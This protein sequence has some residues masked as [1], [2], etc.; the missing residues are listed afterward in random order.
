MRITPSLNNTWTCND[1]DPCMDLRVHL[2]LDLCVLH[3]LARVTEWWH[4]Q[5]DMIW[6]EHN[7]LHCTVIYFSC[8]K[9][10]ESH[11]S[12][13]I[14]GFNLVYLVLYLN[15]WRT[16]QIN[17]WLLRKL[18]KLYEQEVLVNLHGDHFCVLYNISQNNLL[19]KVQR[20]SSDC[21]FKTTDAYKAWI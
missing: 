8:L 9:S 13:P 11:L 18:G 3:K 1:I 4:S 7:V 5:S 19:D 10:T 14:N 21:T 2:Y 15:G 12:S 16:E 17:F 20:H 6:A